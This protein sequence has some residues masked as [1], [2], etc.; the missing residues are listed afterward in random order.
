LDEPEAE[1]CQLLRFASPVL[2]DL[3]HMS[4]FYFE[5]AEAWRQAA[6]ALGIVPHA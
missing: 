5:S 6:E 1:I 2:E 4:T 3:T